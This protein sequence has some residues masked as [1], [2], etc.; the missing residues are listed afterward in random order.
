MFL[1]TYSLWSARIM[2]VL[3]NF[4]NFNV[5]AL[6]FRLFYN[7]A[8]NQDCPCIE[9]QCGRH[10]FSANHTMWYFSKHAI[11]IQAQNVVF[12][13]A[14]TLP[15]SATKTFLSLWS[16]LGTPLSLGAAF[17]LRPLLF[18]RPLPLPSLWLALPLELKQGNKRVGFGFLS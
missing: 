11:L 5:D 3:I 16:R 8:S 9:A 12:F 14:H 1:V 6:F 10:K 7:C 17:L 15:L 18:P 4:Q 13:Q 2:M